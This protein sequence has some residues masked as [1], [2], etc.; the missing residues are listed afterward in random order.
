MAKAVAVDA[1]GDVYVA[2]AF[3]RR[4]QKF[5]SDGR[6]LGAWGDGTSKEDQ[7]LKYASGV[8][9]SRDGSVHVSDFFENR[10]TKLRCR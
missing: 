5:S 6:L 9:V 7:A 2:D 4:I 3:N 1:T 8:A 10:I